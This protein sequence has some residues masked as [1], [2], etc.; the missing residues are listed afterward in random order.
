MTHLIE[1][2][3][4]AQPPHT[5]YF[6]AFCLLGPPCRII[7]GLFGSDAHVVEGLLASEKLWCWN[8]FFLPKSLWGQL[9]SLKPCG[10]LTEFFPFPA[11][12][13]ARQS[14]RLVP[15]EGKGA[16][17]APPSLSNKEKPHF[18]LKP[19]KCALGSLWGSLFWK[20]HGQKQ[21]SCGRQAVWCSLSRIECPVFQVSQAHFQASGLPGDL[22]WVFILNGALECGSYLHFVGLSIT[23]PS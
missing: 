12:P 16:H 7:I 11:T 8:C 2:A 22:M 19:Q 23:K 5:D 20:F 17:L 3:P 9:E 13:C 4:G 10:T 6:I 21:Q 14:L 15:Q 1:E 18:A